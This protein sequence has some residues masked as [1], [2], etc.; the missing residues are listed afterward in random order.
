MAAADFHSQLGGTLFQDLLNA[1][2]R[3]RQKIEGVVECGHVQGQSA[4]EERRGRLRNLGI[5]GQPLIKASPVE[6]R[7]HLTD[8]P[9]RTDLVGWLREPF[10]HN[11][12]HPGQAQLAGQH[13]PA[14]PTSDDH[15]IRNHDPP[16]RQRATADTVT[17]RRRCAIVRISRRRIFREFPNPV[18]ICCRPEPGDRNPTILGSGS[19]LRPRILGWTGAGEQR[20]LGANRAP[21]P[22]MDHLHDNQQEP[23]RR[24][25]GEIVIVVGP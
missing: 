4:E 10:Q 22:A 21:D 7:D 11:G 20:M 5:P 3:Q 25:P 19:K 18:S 23:C 24:R 15:D 9:V 6:H 12:T 2:L 1:R 13:Q 16:S 14:R 8:Q 17:L